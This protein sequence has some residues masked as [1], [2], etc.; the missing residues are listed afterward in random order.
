MRHT[1]RALSNV[2]SVF[3]VVRAAALMRVVLRL[4]LLQSSR[5]VASGDSE[6][7]TVVESDESASSPAHAASIVLAI[8]GG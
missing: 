3:T 6:A 7:T 1:A 8:K 4:T 2:S 5:E